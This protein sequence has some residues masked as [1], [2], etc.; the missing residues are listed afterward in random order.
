MEH[1][2]ELA[3]WIYYEDSH[4][5]YCHDC[6]QKRVEEINTKKSLHKINYEDGDLCGYYQDY[7]DSGD[8]ENPHQ[9]HCCECN[10]PL[11]TLGVD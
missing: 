8:D 9:E 4:T 3:C 10:K 1:K 2:K 6:V 5:Y 11:F 7:A